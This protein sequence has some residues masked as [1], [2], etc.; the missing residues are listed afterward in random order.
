VGVRGGGSSIGRW[1]HYEKHLA[2][3]FAALDGG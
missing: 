1:R 3:L 2:P